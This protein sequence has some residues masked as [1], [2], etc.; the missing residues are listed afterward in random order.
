MGNAGNFTAALLLR[1]VPFIHYPDITK[2]IENN[3][4][5]LTKY[6]TNE[7]SHDH[8]FV[9]LGIAMFIFSTT[10][11][12]SYT[13]IGL[14]YLKNIKDILQIQDIYAEIAWRYLI[15]KYDYTQAVIYFINF[16]KSFLVINSTIIEIQQSK[17]HQRMVEI[18][19]EKINQQI[20]ISR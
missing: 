20:M 19:I 15:Y 9:K 13:N 2:S 10:N 7:I 16:I 17:Q 6:L 8:I 12:A 1:E 3:L 4:I 14:D 11:C 18:L 5:N